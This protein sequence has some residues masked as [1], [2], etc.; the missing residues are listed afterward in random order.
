MADRSEWK[1]L[2]HGPIERLAEN[3]WRVEGALPG[4]S[5]R[6]TMIVAR[7]DDGGL[8]LHSPIAMDEARMAELEQLGRPAALL[9]PNG[10]HRLDAPRY[11]ARY[12]EAS[13]YA[14]RGSRK[15][16]SEVVAVDGNYDEYP[17]DGVVAL[18]T[19]A[20]TGDREGAMRVRSADGVTL[21]LNDVMMNM[22]RRPDFL[23]RL[24]TGIFG[25]APGPRI[26]RLSKLALIKDKG[27]LRR[28]LEAYATLTD[29]VRVCVAHDKVASGVEAA[30]ALR[31]AL[32]YL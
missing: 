19:L 26:S 17:A 18:D 27:A 9:V 5:L 16:V 29:L 4:M 2:E 28:E 11:K 23:G 8:V 3:L 30:A 24:M 22:D 6:R 13:V 14:P 31:Q 12:P 15:Q 25:S 20:S 10:Y 21:V 32:T 7:R 1:V